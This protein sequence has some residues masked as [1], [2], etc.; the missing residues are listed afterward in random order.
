MWLVERRIEDW[1]ERY[2]HYLP[3]TAPRETFDDDSL[4]TPFMLLLLQLFLCF[5]ISMQTSSRCSIKSLHRLEISMKLI[6]MPLALIVF[7]F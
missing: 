7:A 1:N 5:D 3:E 2:R 6:L 4:S